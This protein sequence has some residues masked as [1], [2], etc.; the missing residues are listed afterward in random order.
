MQQEIRKQIISR[1]EIDTLTDEESEKIIKKLDSNIQ[2]SIALHVL[3]VLEEKDR[4]ELSILMEFGNNEDID[5]F[6]KSKIPNLKDL[7]ETLAT[8][9]VSEFVNSV[10]KK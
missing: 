1:L 4:E 8:S 6:L 7:I 3:N 9:M 10:Q 2:R 5:L